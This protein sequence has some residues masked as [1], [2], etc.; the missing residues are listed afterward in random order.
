MAVESYYVDDNGR[1][2]TQPLTS[3]VVVYTVTINNGGKVETIQLASIIEGK[4]CK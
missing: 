1:V 3:E 2:H 4:Y